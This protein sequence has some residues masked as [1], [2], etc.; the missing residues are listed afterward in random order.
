MLLV[1]VRTNRSLLTHCLEKLFRSHLDTR[2]KVETLNNQ[3]VCATYP[4]RRDGDRT[5]THCGMCL[6]AGHFC[7]F[8]A[9]RAINLIQIRFEGFTILGE[10]FVFLLHV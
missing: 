9:R 6:H 3:S 5:R 10:A 7:A 8:N 4:L 2:R 1:K